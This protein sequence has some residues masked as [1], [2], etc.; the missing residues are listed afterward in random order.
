MLPDAKLNDLLEL[1]TGRKELLMR[2]VRLV[3]QLVD[4]GVGDREKPLKPDDAEDSEE[5]LNAKKKMLDR[6]W[7]DHDMSLAKKKLIKKKKRRV[8]VDFS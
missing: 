6:G 1:F 3:K 2:L 4:E 7:M 8:E 5:D